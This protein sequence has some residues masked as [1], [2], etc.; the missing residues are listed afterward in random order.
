ME[1]ESRKMSSFSKPFFGVY[2]SKNGSS[3]PLLVWL[4]SSIVSRTF[5]M[6]LL[7]SVF[8]TISA[9]E[10]VNGT[11]PGVT[12]PIFSASGGE[13]IMNTPVH[14]RVHIHLI[15]RTDGTGGIGFDDALES[16]GVL[17]SYFNPHDIF[18]QVDESCTFDTINNTFFYDNYYTEFCNILAYRP[19]MTN[20]MN[21]YFGGDEFFQSWANG[22][23]NGTPSN[24]ML[25]GGYQSPFGGGQSLNR[26]NYIIAHE[27]G[28]CLGLFHTYHGTSGGGVS[29][30]CFGV[31]LQTTCAELVNGSNAAICGDLV[32]D[33]PADPFF[34]L[35]PTHCSYNPN[36]NVVDAN[37]DPY[38]PDIKNIMAQSRPGCAQHFTEGQGARMRNMCLN[39]PLL[40]NTVMAPS[41][42][43]DA[44][45]VF[46]VSSKCAQVQFFS[47]DNSG[48]HVWD[49]GDG[50]PGSS[51]PNPLYDYLT[52]GN[53]LVTHT[54]IVN[55]CIQSSQ[56]YWITHP[57]NNLGCTF[58]PTPD[59]TITSDVSNPKCTK[60][61]TALNPGNY[62]SISWDFG[63]GRTGT[64]NPVTHTYII[65]GFTFDVCMT[66][67][68]LSNPDIVVTVCKEVYIDASCDDCERLPQLL[69]P[70]IL[71][72]GSQIPGFAVYTANV[73]FEVPKG[74]G[75]CDDGE[76]PHWSE[77]FDDIEIEAYFDVTDTT[78]DKVYLGITMVVP[79]GTPFPLENSTYV[80]LCN[81]NGD[82]I[83]RSFRFVI[84]T[85]HQCITPDPSTAVCD[86]P[87]P[88]DNDFVY[89]G[90][91]ELI[92]PVPAGSYTM[93]TNTTSEARF[94]IT[95]FTQNGNISRTIH[96]QITTDDPNYDGT[97]VTFCLGG[98]PSSLR[99]C[100]P[101]Q[102]L[103]S[104]IC[105][106]EPPPT[107][108]VENWLPKV[109]ECTSVNQLTGKVIFDLDPM[110]LE[111]QNGTYQLC[112]DELDATLE[113]GGTVIVEDGYILPNGTDLFFNIRIELPLVGFQ[114][115]E[116]HDLRLYV[117]TNTGE[118]V[119][120]RVPIIFN[121]ERLPGGEGGGG[122][123]GGGGG[124]P[125]KGEFGKRHLIFP[126]PT[127]GLLVVSSFGYEIGE[128]GEFRLYDHVGRTVFTSELSDG[129]REYNFNQFHPG[130]YFATILV[131][132]KVKTTE[133]VVLLR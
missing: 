114:S 88:T 77:G 132:G 71:E 82:E 73:S 42:L 105:A 56:S 54:V 66:V 122:G 49:F 90:S 89:T 3:T 6:A 44:D 50:S 64:G 102:I 133:K 36:G 75:Y 119:C 43:P 124:R 37:G 40:Q 65:G 86:D 26:T 59:F 76:L 97:F 58:D 7:L 67:T 84:Q 108:C 55:D 23:A 16:V 47:N 28:H 17:N 127:T 120:F 62:G 83:C 8:N 93:C 52:A 27:M 4:Q 10:I 38:E 29:F 117:C 94:V 9:Q 33:T 11:I 96:Y 32:E 21:I 25:V 100:Y 113:G 112:G 126:N 61:F 72:C 34:A 115:G 18:F 101:T 85:C 24:A 15:K 99:Y 104:E 5:W 2:N 123:I 41:S 22:R 20:G 51:V 91:V 130:I 78:I 48:T 79:A 57:C 109:F 98:G 39:D 60:I 106:P 63:D 116:V 128:I 31:P 19:P 14:I 30:N 69:H 53:Y 107:S 70:I 46:F 80:V 95:G 35:S 13:K 87:N 12:P 118:V 110:T 81:E 111:G 45:F 1:K 103:V 121:C 131:D 125:A 68:C 74:Y 92:Y 129:R